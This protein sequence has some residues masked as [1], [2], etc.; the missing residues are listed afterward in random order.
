MNEAMQVAL[1]VDSAMYEVRTDIRLRNCFQSSGGAGASPTPL[2]IGNV[3]SSRT[4]RKWQGSS[5]GVGIRNRNLLQQDLIN[6]ACF[7]CHKN[8]CISRFHDER[9]K[10]PQANIS[11]AMI[12]DEESNDIEDQ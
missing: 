12:S 11:T 5:N 4:Y 1:N 10:N 9:R 8:T 6:G 2:E 3:Q 7:V